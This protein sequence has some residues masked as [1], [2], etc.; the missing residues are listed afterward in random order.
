[1]SGLPTFT[2]R[3]ALKWTAAALSGLGVSDVLRADSFPNR[4]ISIVV[5][6]ATGGYNDRLAR[7]FQPFLQREIDQPLVIVNRP[8]AGSL[9]GN[10]YFSRQPDD[11]Y[12]IL[13]G[14]AAPYIPTSIL[15]HNAP[16]TISDFWMINLPSRDYTLAATAT[17]SGIEGWAQVL[18]TL[19]NDPRALSLGVQPGSS[20]LLN[21]MLALEAEGIDRQGLRIVTYDGGGPAR[22]ATAGGHIDVGF[23]G[24]EG[25]LPLRQSIKPL[26]LFASDAAHGFE[27]TL[28]AAQYGDAT[29]IE[30][31]FIDGSQR[32]WAVHA[33]LREKHPERY[34]LLEKAVER[35]TRNP[36]C[37]QA[38]QQQQL[39]TNWYGPQESNAAYRRT[40][41]A[42]Q[43][44]AHLLERN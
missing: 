8:G 29:G 28:T 17:G 20:D 18:D 15:L 43:R 21:L 39:A 38:L 26:L 37:I 42:M 5:P 23:V 32:G 33:S 27:D 12:T 30:M 31:E 40:F 16:Y 4:P 6:F 36:D 41:E 25:F 1:M 13:C 9:L 10:T 3:T 35:A 22:T 2:R 34:A 19:K 24:A 7:A 11:G 44:H 14:S